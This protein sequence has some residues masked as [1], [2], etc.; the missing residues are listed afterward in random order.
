MQIIKKLFKLLFCRKGGGDIQS[1]WL[2]KYV[3]GSS[4]GYYF[5]N[6]QSAGVDLGGRTNLHDSS[7]VKDISTDVRRGDQPK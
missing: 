2:V 3:G 7:R 5:N 6:V 4:G 1:S